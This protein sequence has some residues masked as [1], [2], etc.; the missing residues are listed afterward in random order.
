MSKTSIFL[1]GIPASDE[2]RNIG[3]VQSAHRLIERVFEL[4][5]SIQLAKSL[6]LLMFTIHLLLVRS[7]LALAR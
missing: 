1:E 2:V 3:P 5:I 4:R 6:R 7:R